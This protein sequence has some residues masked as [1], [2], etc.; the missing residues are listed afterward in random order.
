MCK[1]DRI[2][3][4]YFC[5]NAI[6]KENWSF[7]MKDHNTEALMQE[8]EQFR[9]EKQKIRDVVG[10]IGGATES[11]RDKILNIIFIVAICVLFFLDTLRHIFGIAIPLPP[12]LSIELGL[13]M[14]SL[15]II[16]MISK[17]TRVEHFQFWILNS[18][19]FRLN[20]VA[21]QL[22]TINKKVDKSISE[23]N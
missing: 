4:K 22:R 10:Q 14:V 16:W 21:K 13:L 3:I 2:S 8:L 6:L 1:Y 15:K 18:I 19:E 12:L 20:D 11:I 9:K 5:K 17:Q 23:K 7:I